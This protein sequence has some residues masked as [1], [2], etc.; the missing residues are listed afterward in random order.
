MHVLCCRH[1]AVQR[2]A[3]QGPDIDRSQ[4]RKSGQNAETAAALHAGHAAATAS[5]AGSGLSTR[6][7][8]SLVGSLMRLRSKCRFQRP[9]ASCVTLALAV[10]GVS[11]SPS[12]ACSVPS[13]RATRRSPACKPLACQLETLTAVCASSRHLQ[14]PA[15]VSNPCDAG[16]GSCWRVPSLCLLS[17]IRQ[18][19]LQVACTGWQLAR[20]PAQG[21]CRERCL[22][23]C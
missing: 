18:S 6:P 1:R 10:A 4:Q 16:L 21:V 20:V 12:S 19:C 15:A 3:A 17:A 14:L 2:Q 23:S 9:S 13:G 8:S 5:G 22:Q 11:G 7:T